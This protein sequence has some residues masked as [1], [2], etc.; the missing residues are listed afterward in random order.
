[1]SA[2]AAAAGL[3]FDPYVITVILASAVFGI[4]VGAIPGLT[5]TMAT[6]LLVPITFF[7]PPVPALGAIVTASAMAIFAGDIPGAMLRMPGTPASAAYTDESYAMARK[8][9]LELN[10]GANLFFS[11]AGGLVGVIFLIGAAPLLAEAALNFSS[12]EYFWLACL[13]LSCATLIT[14]SGRTR[15][16]LAM[17]IGLGIGCVGMDPVAGYPRFTFGSV[18][19]MS[20]ISF[21][22]T[23]IGAFAVSELLRGALSQNDTG[24]LVQEKVGALF[25]GIGE[26][27]RRYWRSFLRGLD[28]RALSTSISYVNSNG[29]HFKNQ[30]GDVISHVLFHASYHRGQLAL[31]L[32]GAGHEAPYTDFIHAVREGTFDAGGD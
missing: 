14:S 6:A 31:T 18:D 9:Q 30:I 4:F 29:K 7:M 25:R 2:I 23:M 11:V 8:G 27:A 12:F 28:A 1:M 3:V 22:P 15:A 10:L 17:L 32:R 21:I 16:V 26:V 19:L 5:A 13:G 20:G 24:A